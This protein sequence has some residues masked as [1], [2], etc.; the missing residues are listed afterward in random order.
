ML[1]A[2]SSA[3]TP[4]TRPRA[5]GAAQPAILVPPK[6]ARLLFGGDLMQHL[7]QVEA[8]QRAAAAKGVEGFDYSE[9]FAALKARF[10]AAD[11]VVVNFETTLTEREPYTGYPLFR[12][13]VALARAMREAGVHVALLANN[14][15]C[16]GGLRGV[17]TTVR[18][19]A[20]HGIRHTGLFVDSLD[21][22]HR[23][24]LYLK[25]NGIR[26]ALLDYT[27]GT[28]GMP[29]P[30]GVIVNRIDTVQMAA[31]LREARAANPDCIAVCVHW[32]N[33]YER[34]PNASQRAL[35]A[36]LRHHGAHLVIGSHPHVV[37]PLEVDSA[38]VVVWSLGNLVSNQRR[39]YCDGGL[40][41]E[42]TVTKH[43]DG[44]MEYALEP[45]PVWVALP[46]YRILPPEVA[47][48]LSL[49]AAYRTFRDDCRELLG[50]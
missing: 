20:G 9:S 48:T 15:C 35:A 38:G 36:F 14:H 19:L 23:N 33:E 47:D 11:L 26:L 34:R 5:E 6:R 37:Q 13:P 40:L 49:G 30:R 25:C 42:I 3:C 22:E 41:A 8:A 32:G 45:I 43:A 27:Y 12:S 28:N 29:T 10:R 2:L 17:Q 18:E 16:D 50:L 4:P 44:R 31:D 24:P 7:P 1:L 21:Y 39:R 46:G